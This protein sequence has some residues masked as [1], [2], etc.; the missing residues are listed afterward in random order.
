MCTA[1]AP[2]PNRQQQAGVGPLPSRTPSP[3]GHQGHQQRSFRSQ[4][5][6][7]NRTSEVLELSLGPQAQAVYKCTV[8]LY[9]VQTRRKPRRGGGR[10]KE[11][12]RKNGRAAKE[13][14][15]AQALRMLRLW[16]KV[17]LVACVQWT[18]CSGCPSSSWDGALAGDGVQFFS[19][20]WLRST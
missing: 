3:V 19:S 10:S 9:F 16:C 14:T 5:C 15:E 6:C 17:Q 12:Q 13:R 7:T 4:A 8:K 20:S 11:E 1:K 2:P 18:Q